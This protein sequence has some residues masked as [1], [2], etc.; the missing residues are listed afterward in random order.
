[1]KWDA[2][3]NRERD[4]RNWING[5]GTFVGN[6]WRIMIQGVGGGA[7]Y[8]DA[9]RFPINAESGY[10]RHKR[11]IRDRNRRERVRNAGTGFAG[12]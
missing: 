3:S 8:F 6:D 9:S 11:R 7:K 1:V 10:L 5:V 2:G 12:M 4:P